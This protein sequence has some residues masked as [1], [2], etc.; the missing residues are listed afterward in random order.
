[1]P[2][3]ANSHEKLERFQF[4]TGGP[5]VGLFFQAAHDHLLEIARRCNVTWEI[6]NTGF[7]F[8]ISLFH[9]LGLE[10]RSAKSECITDNTETPNIDLAS[11]AFGL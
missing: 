8:L 3:E 9:V 2:C 6:E 1:M 4:D 5:F 10:G 11:M 7:Y